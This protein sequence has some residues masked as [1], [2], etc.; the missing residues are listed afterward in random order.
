[1]SVKEETYHM[2]ILTV[3]GAQLTEELHEKLVPYYYFSDVD[4]AEDVNERYYTS[5]PETLVSEVNS[6][7]N[8]FNQKQTILGKEEFIQIYM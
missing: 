8:S 4:E 3:E 7:A 5:V 6:F 2:R 1:M